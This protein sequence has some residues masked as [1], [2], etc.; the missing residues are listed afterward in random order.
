MTLIKTGSKR[1][2]TT[3]FIDN[4]QQVI[5]R[6][7]KNE[8]I[9]H[10]FYSTKAKHAPG[11]NEYE[12]QYPGEWRTSA[13]EMDFGIRGIYLKRA[14]R[15]VNITIQAAMIVLDTPIIHTVEYFYA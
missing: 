14:S 5:K 2:P 12:F 10:V 11:T 7:I 4:D 6:A 1:H 9:E 13:N 3:K 8:M 15:T